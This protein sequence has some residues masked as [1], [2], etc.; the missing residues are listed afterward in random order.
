LA[1][2]AF[3]TFGLVPNVGDGEQVQR[4][5][6][7]LCADFFRER[8]HHGRIGQVLLLRGC[9]HHQVFL[10]QPPD[11]L[12]VVSGQAVLATEAPRVARAQLRMV[13]TAPLRDVVEQPGEI[14][15]FAAL[16][17]GHQA[18]TRRIF[19]RMLCLGEAAQI[20][21]HHQD[22]FVD[23]VDVKKIVLHLAHDAPEHRHI[24]AEDS[25]QV[26]AAQLVQQSEADAEHL[27]EPR[28]VGGVAPERRVDEPPVPPQ[29]PQRARRHAPQRAVLLHHQERIEHGRRALREQAF[30]A[31]VEQFVHR[32]EFG[33]ERDRR[34]GSRVQPR[35][36]VLQQDDVDLPHQ[37]GGPVIALHQL[38]AGPLRRRVGHVELFS[39]RRLLVEHQSILAPAGQVVQAHADRADE[40]F[41]P[42]NGAR[43]R[44]GHQPVPRE[45]HPRSPQSGGTADPQHRLQ[46]A[47]AARA[48]LDVGLKVVDSVIE[49]LVALLLLEG[50]GG[51]ET[52][53]VHACLEH[54]AEVPQQPARA[55][56]K[57]VFQQARANRGVAGHLRSTL[58]HRPDGMAQFDAD[59]PQR[60][61]VALDGRGG[62]LPL[63]GQQDQDVDVGM[64]EKLAAAIAPDRKQGQIRGHARFAPDIAHDAVD[65]AR[66]F[67]QQFRRVG[68]GEKRL[69]QR[70]PSAFQLVAPEAEASPSH[71]N[72]GPVVRGSGCKRWR[73]RHGCRNQATGGG[74]GAPA[75]VVSTSTPV[76]VTSTVCSHCAESE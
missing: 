56:K 65:Q 63:F 2:H 55:M 1:F 5:Q 23:G 46:V 45:F 3:Q 15:H 52:A 6:P 47:Q 34:R 60:R 37:L 67:S 17:I 68:L 74:R 35:M 16:E 40:P 58:A 44:D 66:V 10:H 28:A 19:V 54:G 76:S 39:Q 41:L 72:A 22:V 13:A 57:A 36:Q 71:R 62:S 14:Q 30:V 25:E 33:I 4:R 49:L 29:R 9:R 32:L 24:L 27:D 18:R 42:G 38:L 75:E 20:A 64:R 21:D 48:F 73:G 59:V 31:H 51:I 50:L 12:A 11:Q 8:G 7:A 69:A 43:L 61:E 70:L 26:H 53:H